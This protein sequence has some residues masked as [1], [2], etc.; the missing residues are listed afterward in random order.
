M[1]L[2]GVSTKHDIDVVVEIDVAGFSVLW[3]VEC[4][5]WS[6]PVSKLHV[7]G[8]REIVNDLG[9]DRGIVLREVG[10]QS[11]AKEAANMTNVQVN[12][13]SNL[14]ISSR[15][16]VASFRLKELYDRNADC[17]FKYWEIPKDLR[18][19]GGLRPGFVDVFHYSGARVVDFV[20]K[21]LGL[22]FRGAFPIQIDPFD[23][24]LVSNA[25]PQVVLDVSEV[26]V[27]LEPL[28]IELEQKLDDVASKNEITF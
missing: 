5:H 22:A 20:D 17:K 10:F 11:G 4:R 12:S 26:F 13:L 6:T 28:V 8:L 25:L 1:T 7:L 16:A 15:E 9:A 27:V 14:S 18:I 24:L 21:Y 3:L 2:Q 19:E 23:T